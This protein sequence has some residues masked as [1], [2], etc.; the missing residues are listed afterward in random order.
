M[1]KGHPEKRM[2]LFFQG[3]RRLLIT[4]YSLLIALP[5]F[6]RAAILYPWDILLRI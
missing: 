5:A 2:V 4:D 6:N 3:R 1:S